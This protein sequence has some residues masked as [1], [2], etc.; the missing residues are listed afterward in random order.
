MVSP[1]ERANLASTYTRT[2]TCAR[3][4]RTLTRTARTHRYEVGD[5]R[6]NWDKGV[7][8]K[9][10]ADEG[11]MVVYT[12]PREQLDAQRAQGKGRRPSKTDHSQQHSHRYHDKTTKR[13]GRMVGLKR[14]NTNEFN[15][16]SSILAAGSPTVTT[17]PGNGDAAAMSRSDSQSS[18]GGEGGDA[19]KG[20]AGKNH[21]TS[22]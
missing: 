22:R 14:Q 21:I 8:I 4:T 16:A 18:H 20:D 6:R 13:L 5:P 10:N 1:F 7:V 11:E 2:H 19:G 17:S 12:T 15:E 9:I 3:R